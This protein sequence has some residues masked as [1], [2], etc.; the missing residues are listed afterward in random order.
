MF[1][2]FFRPSEPFRPHLERVPAAIELT[3]FH[4]FHAQLHGIDIQ[5]RGQFLDGHLHGEGP[6]GRPGRGKRV[7]AGVQADGGFTHPDVGAVIPSWYGVA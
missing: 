5:L 4:V 6:L 7:T 1:R 2:K 3:G